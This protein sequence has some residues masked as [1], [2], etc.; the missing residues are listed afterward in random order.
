MVCSVPEEL[1][2]HRLVAKVSS[3]E[4][5]VKIRSP[6]GIRAANSELGHVL[7]HELHRHRA[8]ADR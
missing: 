3:A 4:L 7:V 1:V 5:A 8:L 2:G 6:P